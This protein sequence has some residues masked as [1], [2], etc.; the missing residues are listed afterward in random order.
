LARHQRLNEAQIAALFDP[1]TEQRELVRH[2][3][4]SESDLTAIKRCRGDHNRLGHAL[5]RCYLRYPGRAMRIGERPAAALLAFVAEQIDVLPES[6][7][8]YITEERNRQRH[9]IECQ[10][11]LGLRPFGKR[12]ATELTGALLPQAIE[13]DRLS[14]LAELVM[15]NCRERRIVVPSPAALERLCADL[16]HHARREAHRRLT[17]GLSAEQR[18][19]LDALT[20]RREAGGQTWLTWLR[21]MPE[22]ARPAAMLGVLERLEKVRGIGIEP[23]RGHLVHQARLAQLAREAGRSTVQ[24]VADYERQRRHAT[25]VAI[26]V[27]LS[28]S[29]TDQAIDLFDRMVGAMFRKA[30]GRH[31][32]AFQADARAINDKVRLFARVGAALITGR[33]DQRDGYDAIIALMPW[34]KFC[35]SV[36]EAEALARPD[37]FDAYKNLGEHYAGVRRWSPVFLEAFL[38][39][40]VP[41]SASLMRAIEVLREANR[42]E[43]SSLPKSA[44]TAFVRQRWAA[45]VMPGGMI[46]RR[47]YELCVLSELRDRR[48]SAR[49]RTFRI[50]YWRTSPRSAGS[51]S[52]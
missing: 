24:H 30:E 29:L 11:Q 5:M 6:I 40:S 34:E 49:A 9:A 31:A 20:Q 21:Q 26:S 39:E 48:I 2:Y 8:T 16:R 18:K 43:K 32:R 33:N 45:Q 17:N 35:T 10:E 19:R 25:L 13:N 51:T 28:A 3:T 52:T 50:T 38:F 23:D 7:D 37:E 36:A 44:P 41:A 47:Y 42:S 14:H 4:L 1:P 12:L 15:R 22:D 46:D 27:D